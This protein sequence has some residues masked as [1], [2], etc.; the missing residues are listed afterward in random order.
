MKSFL[1]WVLLNFMSNE[2]SLGSK[3]SKK[4]CVENQWNIVLGQEFSCEVCRVSWYTAIMQHSQTYLPFFKPFTLNFI[5]VSE[6]PNKMAD[7]VSCYHR[8]CHE[9]E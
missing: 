2:K 9:Y 3:S 5:G 8:I 6:H 4:V 7:Y 1:F